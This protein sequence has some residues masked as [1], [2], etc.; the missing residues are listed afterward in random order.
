MFK[1]IL[2]ANRG[3]ITVRII[4]A[5]R[6]MDIPVVVV[7]S[8]ADRTALHVR[9]A[10]EAYCIGPAP[11]VESYLV[12][13]RIIEVAKRSGAEAI[14][15][16]YGFL[17]ENYRFAR[18][19]A[20][21]GLVFIGPSP[22][23]MESM[24][25]KVSA[26]DHMEAAGVP[27]VP[28]TPPLR[29]VEEARRLVG[30]LGYPIMLKPSAGGGGKGMRVV[31]SEE[32]LDDAFTS[33]Q[34][35]ARSSFGDD[36]I[37]A[38]RYV[39]KPRHVEIQVLADTHGNT[40][41]LFERECSIQRRHQKVI[42]EAPS[43][44]ISEATRLAM[45]EAAVQAAR[46]VGYA[47]AGTV[48]FLVDDQ[49]R[50]YFLEMNTRLQVEH[51]V[52]EL[53]TGVDL[54]KMQ[55]L[56]AYGETLPFTQDDLR[57]AGAAVECRIYAEDPD[58]DFMPSPGKI[59]ALR[60]PGGPGIRDDIGVYE[61]YE[62]PLYYD[63][64]LSKLSAWGR[65][66]PEAIGRMRRALSE[67]VIEGIRTNIPFHQRVLRHPD[68]LAGDFDTKF[69]DERFLATKRTSSCPDSQPAL[70]AATLLA[71]W[72]DEESARGSTS[73]EGADTMSSWRVAARQGALR[74][75]G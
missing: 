48:E 71:Y 33:A 50:F 36:T 63:P 4:R 53:I 13:E 49:E 69:I 54:V 35:E 66:R 6:E 29:T 20:D 60:A 12:A 45:G 8:D 51:S 27:L 67:Y 59:T 56:V 68:F 47:G 2:V 26:R 14:H 10:D 61:G 40:V 1:K 25:D 39:S 23:A 44:F 58:R 55:L 22:E 3:E 31:T 64:L 11:S 9:Y 41:H 30:E 37:Y 70:I 18:M 16:G 17:S 75:L 43:P 62:V 34:S 73:S 28:G 42:E 38:E 7:Y 72:R 46:S 21:E 65:D 15:P 52:T 74:R 24:G 57:I 19:C 32:G 5:C